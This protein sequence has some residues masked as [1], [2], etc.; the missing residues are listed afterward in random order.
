MASSGKPSSAT[1][2]ARRDCEICKDLK[3]AHSIDDLSDES[4][5]AAAYRLEECGSL[6][7]CP[8]CHRFYLLTSESD[9]HHYMSSESS[10]RPINK[11]Q[12]LRELA[13]MSPKRAKRWMNALDADAEAA[14]LIKKI[15]SDKA[16][17]A[18]ATMA[19]LHVQRKKW[20]EF[21][22]LLR[23]KN[24]AVRNA[25]IEAVERSLEK[26]P[27]KVIDAVAG[28]LADEDCLRA[29]HAAFSETVYGTKISPL[30]TTLVEC[31]DHDDAKVRALAV[32]LVIHHLDLG[33]GYYIDDTGSGSYRTPPPF[34]FGKSTEAICASLP[35]LVEHILE[36]RPARWADIPSYPRSS[37]ARD[38]PDELNTRIG[39]SEVLRTLINQGKSS[40]ARVRDA[41]AA[42]RPQL[43]EMLRQDKA[44][45]LDSEVYLFLSEVAHED[46]G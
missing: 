42:R 20:G 18:A 30:I 33:S 26:A 10:L 44:T 4:F 40:K 17:E 8:L 41:L 43:L 16:A 15:N 31:F 13:N 29:G 37:R 14:E 27:A 39:A 1:R 22:A 5:P 36:P 11:T 24:P 28:L 34:K 3:D 2:R 45:G 32:D 7:R 25:A 46:D 9:P 6:R 12:A 19:A 23:H 38:F 35:G 21:R